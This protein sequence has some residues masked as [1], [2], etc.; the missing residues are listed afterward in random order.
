MKPISELGYEEAPSPTK[1]EPK[2]PGNGNGAPRKRSWRQEIVQAL[3]AAG[4]AQSPQASVQ[5]LNQSDLSSDA[6]PEAVVAWFQE[7]QTA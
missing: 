2:S 6:S 7:R 1:Q 4:I 5:L 3:I